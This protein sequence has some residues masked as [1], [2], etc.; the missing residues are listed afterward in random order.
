MAYAENRAWAGCW[1]RS[2]VVDATLRD[3]PDAVI[4]FGLAYQASNQVM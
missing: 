2:A 4:L 3:C 1:H